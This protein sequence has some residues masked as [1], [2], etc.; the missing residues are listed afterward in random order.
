MSTT[1]D[2]SCYSPFILSL[3]TA[4]VP[5]D[6]MS[7]TTSWHATS[8]LQTLTVEPQFIN[9]N[10]FDMSVVHCM[11]QDASGQW[12]CKLC[13]AKF[14]NIMML[15]THL[16]TSRSH[17]PTFPTFSTLSAI[18]ICM[19]L[20]EP[21][22]IQM[23]QCYLRAADEDLELALSDL[24]TDTE[25]DSDTDS[26]VSESESDMDN[27]PSDR[28]DASDEENDELVMGKE[29]G[30]EPVWWVPQEEESSELM[31]EDTTSG[32]E[33]EDVRKGSAAANSARNKNVERRSAVGKNVR[34]SRSQTF[35]ANPPHSLSADKKLEWT[36]RRDRV[37]EIEQITKTNRRLNG[38]KVDEDAALAAWNASLH[39]SSWRPNASSATP[40]KSF[41][42]FRN[43]ASLDRKWL[44]ELTEEAQRQQ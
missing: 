17:N 24:D 2:F 37:G 19:L 10:K 32:S 9:F 25:S 14:N 5:M 18:R 11:A 36:F 40:F 34:S 39:P 41:G 20:D 12:S 28:H 30:N 8:P 15:V 27:E 1:K 7:L 21:G 4:S 16:L 44:R 38:K 42:A 13:D 35:S 43:R 22:S 26:D 6:T 3:T 23:L 29:E 31:E 33:D